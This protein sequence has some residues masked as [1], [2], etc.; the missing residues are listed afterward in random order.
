MAILNT[1]ISVSQKSGLLKDRVANSQ[2]TS[3]RL[4]RASALYT[5]TGLEASGDVI[6][7]MALPIGAILHADQCRVSTDGTGGT[8]PVVSQIGDAANGAR[9]SSTS[10][11]LAAGTV[12]VTPVTANK[13]TPYSITAGNEIIKATITF[14]GSLTAGKL[15]RF[16]LAY[17]IP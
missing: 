3:G 7:A 15:I 4:M 17:L 2:N 6:D 1:D 16:D 12:A 9:Y 5:T 10:I 14:T 8:S 11:T 13:V